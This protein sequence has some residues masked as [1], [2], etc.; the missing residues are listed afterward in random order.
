MAIECHSPSA[1]H[2]SHCH[3]LHLCSMSMSN[4]PDTRNQLRRNHRHH[5]LSKY[6]TSRPFLT[7]FSEFCATGSCFSSSHFLLPSCCRPALSL[8]SSRS[9]QMDGSSCSST[10]RYGFGTGKTSIMA[11][12]SIISIHRSYAKPTQAASATLLSPRLF[13]FHTITNKLYYTQNPTKKPPKRSHT[14]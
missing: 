9:P 3:G 12:K 14:K 8:G 11:T 10:E 1:S 7:S 6:T 5:F 2:S 4:E 13:G